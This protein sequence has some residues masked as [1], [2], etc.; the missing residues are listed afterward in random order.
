M[1]AL[2]QGKGRQTTAINFNS[3]GADQDLRML[4]DGSPVMI[5]WLTA[6]AIEGKVFCVQ[7]GL[8]T[9]PDALNATIA[10]G[11]QDVLINVPSGTTIIPV[12]ISIDF[13]DT[14]TAQVM[15]VLAVASNIYDNTGLSATTETIYNMRTDK[16]TNGSQCA[17]YSV[18]TGNGTAVETGNFVEFWRPYAGFAEDGFNGSTSWGVPIFHGA[19]WYIGQA[20]VPPIIVGQGSLSI[21]AS[22]QAGTG[23]ITVMWVEETSTNL[24]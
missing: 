4:R 14:G 5:D 18:V 11:E 3:E 12:Y 15:D 13:E 17:A 21:Y 24:I 20:V 8:L 10:D 1:P 23:F 22:A 7:S 19:K 9:T 2:V 16:A 6:K